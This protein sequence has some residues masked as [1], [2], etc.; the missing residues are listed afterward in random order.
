MGKPVPFTAT[1]IAFLSDIHGNLAALEAVLHE[2]DGRSV[3]Q[4]VALGDHL[5]GGTDPLGVWRRLQSVSARLTAGPSDLAL[6]RLEAT[7]LE[8]TDEHETKMAAAFSET[9]AAIGDLVV[10]QLRRLP[11]QLRLPLLDGSELLAVHGSPA[12]PLAECS[13]EMSDDELSALV[14]DDPANLVLCGA[15]HVPFDRALDGLRLVNVGS[16]GAAPEGMV[17]HY[18][19]VTPSLEG[20][21]V[22]SLYVEYA[23]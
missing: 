9:R 22:E 16:V 23:T 15:S 7:E 14:G 13:H 20:A 17:A 8:P 5:L 18:T 4:V 10:E 2:L 12:D 1:P 6:A 21:S 3:G 11:P 19:V